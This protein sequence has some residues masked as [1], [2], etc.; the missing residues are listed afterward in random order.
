MN[1]KFRLDFSS[2][3]MT[4]A[5][6]ELCLFFLLGSGCEDCDIVM[7]AFKLGE[8]LYIAGYILVF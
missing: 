8:F 3:V 7:S 4:V 6:F 1:F 2:A 5:N